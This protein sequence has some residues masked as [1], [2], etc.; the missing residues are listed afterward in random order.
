LK[1]LLCLILYFIARNTATHNFLTLTASCNKY[2][3]ARVYTI[4]LK[5]PFLFYDWPS[6]STSLIINV[7]TLVDSTSLWLVHFQ[8]HS[9]IALFCVCC[10]IACFLYCFLAYFLAESTN[11][12]CRWR[13]A[14]FQIINWFP[15]RI[16]QVSW[17][18]FNLTRNS[19]RIRIGP[20]NLF[21]KG[22]YVYQ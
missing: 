10:F 3:T 12:I 13:R 6:K 8:N 19:F 2:S 4:L 15:R 20:A 16:R 7:S 18:C 5:L 17:S 21:Q 11:R 22:K 14:P 1:T 9:E